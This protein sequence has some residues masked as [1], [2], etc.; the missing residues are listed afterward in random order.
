MLRRTAGLVI[1]ILEWPGRE[2]KED[3]E[4][5]GRMRRGSEGERKGKVGMKGKWE[6]G[7]GGEWESGEGLGEKRTGRKGKDSEKGGQ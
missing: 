1:K 4:G 2:E 6:G 7:N 5:K 3:G